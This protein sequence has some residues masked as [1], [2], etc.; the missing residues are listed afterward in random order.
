M[1]DSVHDVCFFF[2]CVLEFGS[3]IGLLYY[4][5]VCNIN[6]FLMHICFST[7]KFA[8]YLTETKGRPYSTKDGRYALSEPVVSSEGVKQRR[9][10]YKQTSVDM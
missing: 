8:V 7:I 9:S 2:C 10:T 1:G 5:I 3:W 6:I 4:L